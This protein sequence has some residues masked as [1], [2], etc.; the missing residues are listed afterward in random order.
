MAWSDCPVDRVW[1][2]RGATHIGRR[3]ETVVGPSNH[4]SS[5]IGGSM[6][7]ATVCL[8]RADNAATAGLREPLQEILS[9]EGEAAGW[10]GR[11]LRLDLSDGEGPLIGKNSVLKARVH[12]GG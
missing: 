1:P 12:E 11:L 5:V 9:E 7:L 2:I 8:P 10:A 6:L 4:P 3:F